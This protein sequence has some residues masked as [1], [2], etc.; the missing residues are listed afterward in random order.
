MQVHITLY[1]NLGY[2]LPEGGSRYS[3]SRDVAEGT[4]VEELARVLN[5]PGN[6]PV[7]AV[8]NGIR[9]DRDRV[10]RDGDRINFFRPTGGG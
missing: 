9:V 7:L 5:F 1:G 10:L 4:T 2:Y 8:V 3:L 6:I